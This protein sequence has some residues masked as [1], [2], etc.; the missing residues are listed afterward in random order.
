[1]QHAAWSLHI[2]YVRFVFNSK[3]LVF[4]CRRH[5]R[6]TIN[7]IQI[8]IVLDRVLRVVYASE[9]VNAS[10]VNRS[11]AALRSNIRGGEEDVRR[12]WCALGRV[13]CLV[14][15]DPRHLPRSRP[16][17]GQLTDMASTRGGLCDLTPLPTLL[18]NTE[19]K[20]AIPSSHHVLA[21]PVTK[22]ALPVITLH[23]NHVGRRGTG[24]CRSRGR[25]HS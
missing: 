22:Y 20:V 8:R 19:T 15:G 12:K 7:S 1:M 17:I 23:L 14:Q 25:S 2:S 4:V 6:R 24:G 13:D 10:V 5:G 18:T 11:S 21:I 3:P 16:L 9:Q